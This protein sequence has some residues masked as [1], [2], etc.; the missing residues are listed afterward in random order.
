M[1]ARAKNKD[2]INPWKKRKLALPV[3]DTVQRESMRGLRTEEPITHRHIKGR[4]RMPECDATV[5]FDGAVPLTVFSDAAGGAGFT[6][7]SGYGCDW[8]ESTLSL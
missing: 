7:E 6:F 4:Y 5:L 3:F 8:R 1:M 2:R